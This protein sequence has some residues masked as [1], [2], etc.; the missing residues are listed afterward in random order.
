MSDFVLYK[1][2]LLDLYEYTKRFDERHPPLAYDIE[3]EDFIKVTDTVMERIE[4]GE[5]S[6]IPFI[7]SYKICLEI[8]DE[9]LAQPALEEFRNGAYREMRQKS[10]SKIIAFLWYFEYIDDVKSFEEFE[11]KKID[12][13]ITKWALKNGFELKPGYDDEQQ[14]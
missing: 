13:I 11:S 6:A 3:K 14:E 4:S 1:G 5:I 9:Y 12:K 2:E 8:I 10:H 7:D